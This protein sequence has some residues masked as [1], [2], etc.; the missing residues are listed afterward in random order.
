VNHRLLKTRC[1]KRL[2]KLITIVTLLCLT[3]TSITTSCSAI[4]SRATYIARVND[5]TKTINVIVSGF[6]IEDYQNT[7][8]SK[9]QVEQE[10]QQLEPYLIQIDCR[11]RGTV[12]PQGMEDTHLQ[13]E[14]ISVNVIDFITNVLELCT[15][16]G[17]APLFHH[18]VVDEPYPEKVQN[19]FTVY[20]QLI[21]D[22]RE[23]KDYVSELGIDDLP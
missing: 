7:H 3:L 17:E 16:D 10:L 13:L 18:K 9:A 5:W 15:E 6:R 12:P 21:K 19:I 1:T 20:D 2:L 8:Y 11:I 14:A 22:I 4:N 23:Y